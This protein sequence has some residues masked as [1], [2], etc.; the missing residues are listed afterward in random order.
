LSKYSNLTITSSA[1]ISVCNVNLNGNLYLENSQNSKIKLFDV[2]NQSNC[3]GFSGKF[4]NVYL[5]GVK[6]DCFEITRLY[7]QVFFDEN[8]EAK[9]MRK[10]NLPEKNSKTF[11]FQKFYILF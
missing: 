5:N 7:V 4:S 6:V 11:V 8:F 10:K 1:L 9:K 3:N 2:K